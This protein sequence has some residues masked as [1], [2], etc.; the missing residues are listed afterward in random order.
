MP[1]DHYDPHQDLPDD[2]PVQYRE[3]VCSGREGRCELHGRHREA[4]PRKLRMLLPI[5]GQLPLFP[6]AQDYIDPEVVSHEHDN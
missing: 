4:S 6:Y 5:P 3:P 2:W 1:K